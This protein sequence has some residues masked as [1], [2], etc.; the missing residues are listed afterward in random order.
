MIKYIGKG[1]FIYGI[2]SRDIPQKEWLALG[3]EKRK[4]A[5]ASGLYKEVK[6]RAK[7]E[8]INELHS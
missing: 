4:R 5:L 1:E 3:S 7:R 2:P 8:Q 6:R